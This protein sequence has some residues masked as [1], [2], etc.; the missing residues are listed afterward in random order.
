MKNKYLNPGKLT[1]FSDVYFRVS[2]RVNDGQV[3][4]LFRSHIKL[5][6]LKIEIMY[7]NQPDFL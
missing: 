5:A 6:K 3:K 1:F 7:K 4:H 2:E